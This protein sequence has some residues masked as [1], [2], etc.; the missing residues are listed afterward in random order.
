MTKKRK[1][2]YYIKTHYI[3]KVNFIFVCIFTCVDTL[4]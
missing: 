3:F 4:P 1:M 2:V